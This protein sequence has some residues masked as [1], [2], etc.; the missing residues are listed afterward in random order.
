MLETEFEA[1]I[2][3]K[4]PSFDHPPLRSSRIR[5]SIPCAA[6]YERV[7]ILPRD[8]ILVSR[9][10]RMPRLLIVPRTFPILRRVDRSFTARN[11]SRAH[12]AAEA[13]SLTADDWFVSGT[14][15]RRNTMVIRAG[16]AEAA[17]K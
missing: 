4:I 2:I 14:N 3:D 13:A 7:T 6:S 10:T 12:L 11:K 1:A 17:R 9:A 16:V 5:P 15:A 8:E